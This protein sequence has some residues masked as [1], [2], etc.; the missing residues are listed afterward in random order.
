VNI[1][2]LRFG[3]LRPERRDDLLAAA[4]AAKP[5]YDDIGITLAPHPHA[6]Q[7]ERHLVLG[8][9][10]EV[11]ERAR[12]GLLAWSPHAGI[13]ATVEPTGQPVQLG[14]TILVVLRAGPL[15][16]VAPN[17]VVAVIDEPN[18]FAFAYGTLP[19]HPESGEESFAIE[20][21]DDGSVRAT[22]R[23]H[24]VPATWAARLAAPAVRWL[25]SVALDRYLA[26]IHRYA[27]GAPS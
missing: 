24:A 17:R 4:R 5:T 19:S 2:G 1:G 23:V 3:R 11:F 25:Q 22:I 7:R 12:Q 21:L 9:G 20:R 16:V 8:S 27:T 18:H 6:S 26:S 10:A 15:Y 14:A 13:N